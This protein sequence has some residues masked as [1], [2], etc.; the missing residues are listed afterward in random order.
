MNPML[1]SKD[2]LRLNIN[3]V[4]SV[5]EENAEGRSVYLLVCDHFGSLIPRILGDLGVPSSE[6]KRHIAYDIGIAEVAL[7]LAEALDAH[8]VAQRYSRLVIDCNRPLIAASS[9]P[10]VSER[11]AILGNENLTPGVVAARY[12]RHRRR[13]PRRPT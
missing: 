11:T 10:T 5:L 13:C 4:P 8:L 9:I 6:L 12:R 3:E 1:P 2:I 7:R